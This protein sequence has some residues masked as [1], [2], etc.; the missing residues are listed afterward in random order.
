M[1]RNLILYAGSQ[2]T[3]IKHV[4]LDILCWLVHMLLMANVGLPYLAL[5]C[6]PSKDRLK[7][8]GGLR[9]TRQHGIRKCTAILDRI[10]VSRFADL[11]HKD[12]SPGWL[13][14][15]KSN[16]DIEEGLPENF[17]RVLPIA[18][19]LQCS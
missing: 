15:L 12:S 8:R 17:H 11:G 3:L 2:N 13:D 6:V 10:G 5:F 9:M 1:F 16:M 4:K 14:T 7:L 18:R 19:R